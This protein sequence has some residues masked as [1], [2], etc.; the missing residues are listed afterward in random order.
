MKRRWLEEVNW[1]QAFGRGN[2]KKVAG[3]VIR[4]GDWYLVV[5][6]WKGEINR[7]LLERLIGSG[8]LEIDNWKE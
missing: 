5:S 4:R 6:N 2:E 8:Y 3:R 1:K 7:R